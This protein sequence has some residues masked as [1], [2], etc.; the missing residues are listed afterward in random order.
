MSY[1]LLTVNQSVRKISPTL[2]LMA[3]LFI[4]CE[5][6]GY[7]PPDDHS[8]SKDG[9]MHKPGLTNPIDNCASCHGEDLRG[10]SAA[11]SC[12]ECHGK[13]W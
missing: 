1:H 2:F 4:G 5:D 13:K 3:F 8:L 7:N 12:Y 9:V 10:G 11:V 6:T